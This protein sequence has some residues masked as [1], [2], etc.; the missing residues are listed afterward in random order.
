M[1]KKEKQK[2]IKGIIFNSIFIILFVLFVYNYALGKYEVISSTS[3]EGNNLNIDLNRIKTQGF[4]VDEVQAKF[5]AAGY[6]DTK[7]L[8][9]D[10]NKIDIA[11]KIPEN[12]N[13]TYNEWVD[14]EISKI[15]FYN[16]EIEKNKNILGNIIPTFPDYSILTSSGVNNKLT[17]ETFI[18]FIEDNILKKY[19]LE[20][21]S[22]VGIDNIIFDTSKTNLANIGSFKLN[23]E[24]TGKNNNIKRFIDYIQNSGKI[25]IN[26]GKIA[27]RVTGINDTSSN[28]NNLLISINDLKLDSN[29]I[30][31]NDEN[32][33]SIVLQ[34]YVK[35]IGMEDYI[36][37]R[38]KISKDFIALFAKI[39]TDSKTCDKGV[40]DICADNEGNKAVSDIR[41]LVTQMDAIKL[42][43]DAQ[44]KTKIE[45]PSKEVE[46]LYQIYV[47][48]QSIQ[49]I[50]DKNKQVFNKITKGKK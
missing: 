16:S 26:N 5:L 30:N 18:G 28:L 4:T 40:N 45:D 33:G 41:S 24:F 48:M 25:T 17:L 32:N 47:T 8:F 46:N 36:L 22:S 9:L 3:L 39:L 13:K 29:I 31:S 43:L 19:N 34:F 27:G 6:T 14:D 2:Y 38:N 11:I 21:F 37:I 49:T 50:Y 35:G 20:S 1:E 15:D 42:K 23:L 7:N 12:Y 10:K 44:S